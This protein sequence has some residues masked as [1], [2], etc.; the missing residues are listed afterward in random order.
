MAQRFTRTILLFICEAEG[1]SNV[2]FYH[3]FEDFFCTTLFFLL[4]MSGILFRLIPKSI[5]F[6]YTQVYIMYLTL[7]FPRFLKVCHEGE[8]G[9]PY[10]QTS[11]F[12]VAGYSA[13]QQFIHSLLLYPLYG[14]RIQ[15]AM[16]DGQ[17][18]NTLLL[19]QP[20]SKLI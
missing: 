9:A 2:Q 10:T 11:L 4:Y 5:I 19:I 12:A 1:E 8:G 13:L 15:Q 3:P 16:Q 7:T 14:D 6:W 20:A 18:P 17:D